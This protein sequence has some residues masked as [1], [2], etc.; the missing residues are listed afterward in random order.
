MCACMLLRARVLMLTY[1]FNMTLYL[2]QMWD[3]IFERFKAAYNSFAS[4]YKADFDLTKGNPFDQ[5][6]IDRRFVVNCICRMHEKGGCTWAPNHVILDAY[7]SVGF[8]QQGLDV[9][10]LLENKLIIKKGAIEAGISGGSAAGTAAG[11]L[12]RPAVW[13][14]PEKFK[15]RN[16]KTRTTFPA[17]LMAK[18][19]HV[20]A[21]RD[22]Y[23]VRP[24]EFSEGA[25]RA[26]AMQIAGASNGAILSA[27]MTGSELDQSTNAR[28]HQVKKRS[29][30]NSVTGSLLLNSQ[31]LQDKETVQK[32]VAEKDAKSKENAAKYD[33]LR[34]AFICC[35]RSRSGCTC[36]GTCVQEK[37]K[38]CR[39][40]E[41]RGVKK[42]IQ[43]SACQKTE[44]TLLRDK[45]NGVAT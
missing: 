21:E 11:I 45:A 41:K 24:Q 1:D 3:Q 7:A 25:T 35:K 6:S 43:K 30:I 9:A 15:D 39:Y 31:W 12:P 16:G 26:L 19:E 22:S 40:C 23:M 33:E 18:L 36:E 38:Y 4:H 32:S 20:S 37:Y 17:Y 27:M 28:A 13:S 29:N 2:R 14:T 5:V 34:D 44:C 42:F 8:T 10:K